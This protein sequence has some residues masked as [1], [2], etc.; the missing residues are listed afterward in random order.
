MKK[1][2]LYINKCIFA[3]IISLALFSCDNSTSAQS[4]SKE[5]SNFETASDMLKRA[6]YCFAT[7]DTKN[8]LSISNDLISKFP[9]SKESV[10]A[11]E[12]IDKINLSN[13]REKQLKDEADTK[14]LA[15]AEKLKIDREKKLRVVMQSFNKKIDEIGNF[16]TYE[17][18]KAPRY[19]NSRSVLNPYI[20]LQDGLTFLQFRNI[21]VSDDWLFIESYIVKADDQKFEINPTYSEVKRDNEGGEIWEW[22]EGSTT[23]EEEAMLRAVSN[24]K[25]AV[26]RYSGQQYYK[27]RVISQSE[28]DMIKDTLIAYDAMSKN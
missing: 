4:K 5:N 22:T 26:I 11:N 27:D 3:F 24:S 16:T 2:I 18:K 6:N 19:I 14:A 12:L 17:H 9:N 23:S 10:Q 1:H 7:K 25:K 28:K 21:Y 8:A 20:L 13:A 15:E